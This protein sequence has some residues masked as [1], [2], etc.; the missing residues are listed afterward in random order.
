MTMDDFSLLGFEKRGD[1][2]IGSIHA[3]SVLDALN[4]TRFGEEV[5]RY[6]TQNPGTNLLL[7]FQNVEYLSSAVLTELLRIKQTT[8]Q[9]KGTLRLCGLNDN[10]RKVFEITNLDQVFVIYG[11]QDRA[12]TQYERALALAAEDD[13]WQDS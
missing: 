1:I 2:T 11:A 3:A 4:V 9:T 8:E 7:D 13:A 5:T 12:L 6:L 10:I